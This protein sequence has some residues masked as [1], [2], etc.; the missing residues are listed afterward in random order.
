MRHRAVSVLA[1]VSSM[2]LALGSGACSEGD[3]PGENTDAGARDGATR[4]GAAPMDG[5]ATDT[6][7]T[8]EDAAEDDAPGD[9]STEP[10]LPTPIRYLVIIVKE[11]HT[12]DN[13]F[14]D[15][16]GVTSPA[17]RSVRLS[18]GSTL[19]LTRQIAPFSVFPTGDLVHSHERAVRVWHGGAMDRFDQSASGAVMAS[20]ESF[21]HYPEDQ[22][23][24]YWQYA[25]HFV[26]ADN[27]FASTLAP[28]APGHLAIVS[29]HSLVYANEDCP[30][31]GTCE[32]VEPCDPTNDSTMRHYNPETCTE[33]VGSACFTTG[34]ITE[35]IPPEISWRIYGS[36]PLRFFQHLYD[37]GA[38]HDPAHA[39]PLA[40][41]LG[42]LDVA[43]MA[44][45]TILDISSG[46]EGITEHQAD[47]PC[48]GESYTVG[49]VN[50][51]MNGPHWNET[52][53]V[54]TYDDWGGWYDHVAPHV[55]ACPAPRADQGFNT[56]FRVP[57][58]VISPYSRLGTTGDGLV[59]HTRTEQASIPK[60]VAELFHDPAQPVHFLEDDYAWA[61]DR[62]AGSLLGTLDFTQAPRPPMLLTP[63]TD[64][65][66][67]A[68]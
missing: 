47:H 35:N 3:T 36:T 42:D 45:L 11:N 19:N 14:Y 15:F 13:L 53:I 5:D 61:R 7:A 59:F 27:F 41:L 21:F 30:V 17:P 63:R 24:N 1:L 68:P 38:L 20:H 2:V 8:T 60:L 16:P 50:R 22:V 64:C 57:L 49:I 55:S 10:P 26:L 48:A 9:A 54:V 67:P 28:S 58:M 43:D 46:P 23:P 12:F 56:G 52:A 34:N 33:S 32:H 18:D 4:D 39:R 40:E 65:P 44:N 25:R 62:R 29:A 66:P 51:L 37:S 6:G 31:G